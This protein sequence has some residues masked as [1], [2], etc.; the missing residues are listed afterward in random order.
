MF[1]GL[2]TKTD[3]SHL[4]VFTIFINAIGCYDF[5]SMTSP[6]S[7]FDFLFLSFSGSVYLLR[8]VLLS[9]LSHLEPHKPVFC[10]EKLSSLSCQK[11]SKT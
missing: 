9:F 2:Y 10:S 5:M 6:N 8:T 3:K 1:S 7:K 4:V 11:Q